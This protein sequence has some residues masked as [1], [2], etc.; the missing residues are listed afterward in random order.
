MD[1]RPGYFPG[2][3][4]VRT[5]V[6]KKDYGWS[7]GLV[8]DPSELLEITTARLGVFGVLQPISPPK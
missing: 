6:H 1:D 7:M 2:C 4:Q 5:K 8:Y 3:A